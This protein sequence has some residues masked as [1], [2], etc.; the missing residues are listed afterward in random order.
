MLRTAPRPLTHYDYREMPEGPPY[1]QLIEGE[2]CM[3]PSPNRAHQRILTNI[4]AAISWHVAKTRA[5]EI[6]VA[7]FDVFLTDLNVYQ[8]D[9]VFISKERKSILTDQGAEGAPDLVVEILSPRSAKLDRG[10]KRDI[11]ARTGVQE[12]WIVDPDHQQVEVF[13]LPENADTP[14]ATYTRRQKLRSRIL[15]KFSM[16]VAQIFNYD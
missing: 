3:S 1:Y 14:L 10:V 16:P 2:L 11:Y 13:N 12:L 8:P 15:A 6:Y 4:F 9:L 7:P 5:G